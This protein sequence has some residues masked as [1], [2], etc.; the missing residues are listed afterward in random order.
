MDDKWHQKDEFLHLLQNT[1]QSLELPVAYYPGSRDRWTKYQQQ[2]PNATLWESKQPRTIEDRQLK[3]PMMNA[4]RGDRQATVLPLLCVD[5]T[6]DLSTP[7]GQKDA[8]KQYA[9][10]VEPF[11]PVVTFVTIANK[12]NSL[13][14]YMET[15][16]TLCNGY[17]YGSLSC[18]MSV[19]PA[20]E[21]DPAV[22]SA[23][24]NL[25]YGCIGINL[26]TGL[27]YQFSW[28]GHAAK[29]S[30][31][32]VESGLG[33]IGNY[34]YLPHLQKSVV[35]APFVWSQHFKVNPDY[36]HAKKELEAVA[37]FVRAPGVTTFL[38]LMAI[39]LKLPSLEK[40]TLG[41]A[42]AAVVG[43]AAVALMRKAH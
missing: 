16:V 28:G 29:E 32:H 3:P 20:V 13:K 12:Q 25:M 27:A 41:V 23:I 6:I 10:Q 36:V 33:R 35:K 5:L 24:A 40:I 37:A 31:E 15:A 22:Q 18:S 43:I 8:Q 21:N 1:W 11:C 39:S 38:S 19:P 2:Y 26:W 4:K 30:L 9:F 34:L 17:I 14:D 7:Q 42:G